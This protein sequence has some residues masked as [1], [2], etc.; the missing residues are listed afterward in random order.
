MSSDAEDRIAEER[1]RRLDTEAAV[2]AELLLDI[3]DLEGDEGRP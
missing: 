3:L 2:L 1:Q